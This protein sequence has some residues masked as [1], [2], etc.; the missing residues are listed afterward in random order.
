MSLYYWNMEHNHKLLIVIFIITLSF[1]NIYIGMLVV[2]IIIFYYEYIK[3]KHSEPEY[4]NPSVNKKIPLHIYQTWRTKEELPPKMRECVD[5]LR[6]QNPEFVHHLFDDNDCREF[7]R[8]NY[9]Q[10]ILNAYDSLVPGAY[11][12]DLWRYCI[13]YKKGGVYIDIKFKCANNVKLINLI[14]QEQYVEDRP[15]QGERGI[16][17]GIMICEKGD[18]RLLK[19]IYMIVNNVNE[20]YYGT[21]PLSPTGPGLLGKIFTN[22]E[23]NNTQMKMIAD[24]RNIHINE[25]HKIINKKD[26]N[27]IFVMYPEYRTEQSLYSDISPH[28]DKLWKNKKIYK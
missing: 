22:D 21:T 4:D 24:T 18:R 15:Q 20:K 10:E 2:V 11:K 3:Y 7:I 17:N 5:T 26:N 12:A 13:L 27:V 16:Y 14:H 25:S 8:D 23:F 9:D 19:A 1:I 6:R 28:Y